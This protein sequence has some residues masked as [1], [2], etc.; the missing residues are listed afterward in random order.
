[1]DGYFLGI[2]YSLVGR[3]RAEDDALG[4][5]CSISLRRS[6]SYSWED[7]RRTVPDKLIYHSHNVCLSMSHT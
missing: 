6:V 7:V 4:E 5:L 3:V 1:M 2:S